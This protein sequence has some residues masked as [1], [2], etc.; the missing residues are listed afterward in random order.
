MGGVDV[1]A[2]ADDNE[3][4]DAPPPVPANPVRWDE[5]EP[6]AD[7]RVREL[8]GPGEEEEEEETCVDDDD[9]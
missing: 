2:A 7:G 9:E 4:D 5:P 6:V 3:D 8:L 1:F